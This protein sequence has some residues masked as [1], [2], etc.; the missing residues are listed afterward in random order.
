M[1]TIADIRKQYPQYNDLSDDELADGLYRKFYSDLPQE[2]F[3]KRIQHTPEPGTLTEIGRGVVRSVGNVVGGFAKPVEDV[4]GK[5]AAS[6][7]LRESGEDIT[8]SV[9]PRT[10]PGMYEAYDEG[11]ILGALKSAAVTVSEGAVPTLSGVIVGALTKNPAAAM[12]VMGLTG[13]PATYTGIREQ[14]EQTGFDNKAAAVVGTAA[15]TALDVLT[16]GGAAVANIGR[17]A[18][19]EMFESGMRKAA[20][21]VAKTGAEEAGTEAIQNVIEQVAGGADP[22]TKDSLKQTLEAGVAGLV[23]GTFFGG[24]SE[25]TNSIIANRYRKAATEVPP[26][27]SVDILREGQDSPDTI[28]I[29]SA[30][31]EDGMVIARGPNGTVFNTSLDA[32]EEMRADVADEARVPLRDA[33]SAAVTRREASSPAAQSALDEA[34]AKVIQTPED[35]TAFDELVKRYT[36]LVGIPEEQAKQ[37]ALGAIRPQA[38]PATAAPEAVEPI[39]EPTVAAPPAAAPT[40]TAAPEPTPAPPV[41]E[42]AAPAPEPAPVAEA[43]PVVEPYTVKTAVDEYMRRA[44]AQDT[45]PNLELEQFIANNAAEVNAEF[46]RRAGEP[47]PAPELAEEATSEPTPAPEL[48]EEATSEPTLAPELT[49]E[50]PPEPVEEAPVEE[51]EVP[52]T[53]LPAGTA[54]GAKP[55]QRGAQGTQRGRPVE[56]A[57]QLTGGMRAQQE[58]VSALEAAR[59]ARE[60]SDAEVAEVT[61]MMRPPTSERALRA[62]PT[63]QRNQWLGAIQAQREVDE[64]QQRVSQLPRSVLGQPNPERMDLEQALGKLQQRLDVAQRDIVN[65]ARKRLDTAR[66]KRAERVKAIRRVLRED[67]PS[68]AERRELLIG[69]RENTV[70][71]AQEDTG[72]FTNDPSAEESV[73]VESGVAGKSYAEALDWVVAN[74]P[75]GTY[76]VVAEAVRRSAMKLA[77]LGWKFEFAV[78]KEGDM[79]PVAMRGARGY[80]LVKFDKRTTKIWLN[81]SEFEGRVGTSYQTLLHEMV[82]S[83]VTGTIAVTNINK[84]AG[85]KTGQAVND[86]YDVFNKVIEHFNARVKSG[87]PL[88]P[89]ENGVYKRINN[90]LANPDEL[91][92]WTLSNPEVMRYLDTIPYAPK[93]SIFGRIVEAVRNILGLAKNYDSALA[94][95]LRTGEAIIDAPSSE[96]AEAFNYQNQRLDEQAIGRKQEEQAQSATKKINRGVFKAQMA[97]SAAG[98][99]EGVDE[100]AEGAKLTA[101]EK[102]EAT[103]DARSST[104]TPIA[105]ELKPTS[106]LRDNIKKIRPAVG[107]IL[108]GIDKLEQAMRGMRSS[109]QKAMRRRVK[110]VERFTNKYGQDALSQMMTLARVNRFNPAEYK[111]RQEA[112]Q[113]DAVLQHYTQKNNKRGIDARTDEIN[114][115]WTAW[116]RLGKQE[117]GHETYLRMRQF[118]KDMYAALRAA[119]DQDIRNLGLDPASTENLL[120]AARGEL[121][122]DGN[123]EEDAVLGEGDKH[124]GVPEDLFP[125]EYFPF[126]RFGEFALIVKTDKRTERERYHFETAKERNE[127]KAKRAKQLGLVRG[128]DAYNEAFGEELD[129]LQSMRDNMRNESFL[130]KRLFEA[131]DAIKEPGTTTGESTDKFKNNL[132]D[133]IYQTY[134]MTLPERNLRRQFI[135]AELVTGQSADVLRVFKVSAA[136]YASQLPKVMYGGPIQTQI[137][138]AF[139]TAKEGDPTE[140]AKLRSLLNIYA[141]RVRSAITPEQVG[142]FEQT[143]NELT[144]MS[145]MTSVASAAVQPLT[146]PFQV[147]PRLISRYGFDGAYKTLSMY[148]PLLNVV[149]IA[150]EEDPATG[151]RWLVAPSI[152]NT[153]FI[154]NNPLRARLWRELDVKRDLFS[155]KQVDMLLRN[156]PTRG[157]VGASKRERAYA[158]YQDIVNVSGALFGSADQL[159]REMAGMSYAELEYA[160]LRKKGKSHEDAIAGAVDAAVQ[161][162]NETIGNYTELEKPGIFRGNAFKRM[163][164]FLRTYSVQRTAYYFR[165]FG[166]LYKGA[167]TQTRLEAAKELSMVLAFTAVGA[168]VGA[169]F[170]YSLVCNT[171]DTMLALVLSDDDKEEWRRRDPLGADD[172]DYRFRFE[173]LPQ[174]FGADYPTMTRFLQRG[175]LSE[176][177]GWEFSTRLSQNDLWLRDVRSA[178][179]RREY[180]VN[181]L[182]ANLAPQVSQSA[183]VIDA[184]DLFADGKWSKGFGKLMPAAVRGAFNAERFATEGETT[185]AG[186]VVMG[187]SE[188]TDT[189]LVG[190]VLGFTPSELT[191]VR[192][193]NRTIESYHRAMN[194]ERGKLFDEYREILADESTTRA[195]IDELIERVRAYNR[196]LPL[197]KDGR[198]LSKFRIDAK[199]LIKS[200]TGAATRTAKSYRGVE[201][202]PG[203]GASYF[204]Y[205]KWEPAAQ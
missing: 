114:A 150:R 71:R 82:H 19:L 141:G 200:L 137:E 68:E 93:Q 77:G 201:Y 34:V 191:R 123:V 104:I 169:N 153:D 16:G 69:L 61:A 116:E 152:G 60:I 89:L 20:K 160:K 107:E 66:R 113:K 149:N 186:R 179:T 205:E 154:K 180:I 30:P 176:L 65:G 138:A 97:S 10:T 42:P 45:S 162:T 51:P 125:E 3:Y 119:Q 57:A 158:T 47:T 17:K 193:V 4:F 189:A 92:A 100:A 90:T 167:P 112:L 185:K 86:L 5:N 62:L 105:A 108:E 22:L 98:I 38:T 6:D 53:V 23:G 165:M 81:G 73:K 14:Q 12:S 174:N 43:A 87:E 131:I 76:K 50:T 106:W 101:K 1:P 9:A 28:D 74:A 41:V 198:P 109:M 96:L 156:R 151:E 27:H 140:R 102:R 173:W 118:Y 126:R 103:R 194:T 117:G 144:F 21:E 37:L 72:K 157:T 161:N 128:T 11:G 147:M 142:K 49:E 204:P 172:A 52:V 15:S 139:D 2:E 91:L 130:L 122:K 44:M 110:E 188:F 84:F 159:A 40:P 115:S 94:E 187:A 120:R 190:Q 56:G 143:V 132:K 145:I 170:G 46:V 75:N 25:G 195:D 24:V 70:Q 39:P 148:T 26:L 32:L 178:D 48:V 177:T 59:K 54:R 64:M 35:K 13:A 58:L 134:L 166:A 197:D 203:E 121:D 80:T 79:A 199:D 183:N 31:T 67:N 111:T 95:V 36:T 135:H 192:E 83:V 129:G 8:G 33:V 146:L 133:R 88:T 55:V 181:F 63:E 78:V 182:S 136:Q 171:I 7:W 29:I 196:K 164:G 127:F 184:V 85:T 175:A 99:L 202:A 124:A 163:I 168:G 18:I 155:Q